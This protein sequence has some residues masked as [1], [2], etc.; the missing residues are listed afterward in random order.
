CAPAAAW[1]PPP[2]SSGS[3]ARPGLPRSPRSRDMIQFAPVQLS[4]D[5]LELRNEVVE[6]LQRE[7]PRGT[8]QP[9]LGMN[10]AKDPAFSRKLGERGWLGMALP[11]AYGGHDR[12]AV[13]RF[14]VVEQLL[15]WGAP[16]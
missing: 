9:G 14:I 12:S 3:D 4:D 6:F 13:D 15:R 11:T 7:L 16:V 10:A 8:F 1:A 5:E 2:S